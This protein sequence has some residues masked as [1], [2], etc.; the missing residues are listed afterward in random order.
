M[1]GGGRKDKA[2][3]YNKK[4]VEDYPEGHFIF[5][6]SINN[7]SAKLLTC[8]RLQKKELLKEYNETVQKANIKEDEYFSHVN[9]ACYLEGFLMAI[10]WF[11]S[12]INLRLQK[13]KE[14]KL[15]KKIT[16]EENVVSFVRPSQG[17]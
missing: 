2:T 5:D 1:K 4:G 15:L 3:H 12:H 6:A 7:R 13:E 8:L 14:K 11:E 16:G 17:R 10:S 9:H